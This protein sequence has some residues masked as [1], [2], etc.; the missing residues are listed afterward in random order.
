MEQ[1]HLACGGWEKWKDRGIEGLRDGGS[2]ERTTERR[3]QDQERESPASS[4][5]TESSIYRLS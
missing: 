3:E 4:S 5:Q 2:G 1:R